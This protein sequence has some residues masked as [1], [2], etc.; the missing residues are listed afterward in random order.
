MTATIPL[1]RQAVKAWPRH[2]LATRQQVRA[3]RTGYIKARR[4]LKRMTDEK[5]QK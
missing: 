1:L 4:I 3:L 2:E 5:E